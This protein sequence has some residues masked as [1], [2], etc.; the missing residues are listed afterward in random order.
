M[1]GDISSPSIAF[2][3]IQ[4]GDKMSIEIIDKIKAKNNGSF[5]IADASDVEYTNSAMTGV[6]NVSEAI[7]T[8]YGILN[9]APTLSYVDEDG[10][11]DGEKKYWEIGQQMSLVFQFTSSASGKCT[12]SITRNGLSY[13]TISTNKGRI[14]VDLGVA[15]TQNNYTYVVSGIDSIGRD[16]NQVLT[17][18]QVLGGVELASTFDTV[19]KNTVFT[20]NTDNNVT[21]PVSITYAEPG[22]PRNILYAIKN[23][24]T[25][26]IITSGEYTCGDR[27]WS[28]NIELQNIAF[29]APGTYNLTIQGK[30]S[31]GNTDLL[32]NALSYDFAAIAINSI[33]TTVVDFNADNLT[34]DTALSIA[35][36]TVTNV[37]ALVNTAK[38]MAVKCYLYRDQ[39]TAPIKE[40]RITGISSGENKIWNI[41]RLSNPGEYKYKLVGEPMS[42]TASTIT[43]QKSEG[44]FS[45]TQADTIGSSYETSNLI[46]YFDAN[47]MD[48]NSNNP[49][50]WP[51]SNDSSYYF[52]LHGLNYDRNGWLID[53]SDQSKM[54]KFSGDSYGEL[55]HITSSGTDEAYSPISL[56]N[57]ASL[58]NTF[59]IVFRTRCIGVMDTCVIS[60]R[61]EAITNY[62]G[63]SI[64]YDSAK[65][66][67]NEQSAT[68][69]INES[70][71]KFTHVAFVID[72]NI[73]QLK[74]NSATGTI[75]N[76]N[77]EDLNTVATMNIYVNG[78]RTKVIAVKDNEQFANTI[79]Y[80]SMQL[81]LNGYY[82]KTLREITGFGSCEIK[83]IRIYNAALTAS[84]VVGNYI[85]SVID[86]SKRQA[87]INKNDTNK[88]DIPVIRFVRNKTIDEDNNVAYSKYSADKSFSILNSIK[89]KKA[90][91]PNIPTSKN[92]WT[93]CTMWYTYLDK[94]QEI[95][96]TVKYE[97]VDVYLQG[98]SSLQFP[99]KNYK[100]KC[101]KTVDG[102]RGGKYKFIPPNK[103]GDP[104]WQIPDSVYTLKCD[105][106]EESHK[107]NTPTAAMYETVLDKVIEACQ[108][109]NYG[110][111][112]S[113]CKRADSNYAYSDAYATVEIDDNSIQVKKY[114]D[115]I[116]GFPVLLYYNENDTV[117]ST[118][119]IPVDYNALSN[120][121]DGYYV[122]DK[123]VMVGTMMFNLD[124]SSTALG[125]EPKWGE[126]I[127]VK[128]PITGEQ[129]KYT[130]GTDVVLTTVPCISVEG[131]S[132]SSIPSAASFYTREEANEFTYNEYVKEKYNTLIKSGVI[133][134]DTTYED[135]YADV[136]AANIYTD[137][138]THDEYM[139]NG[140]GIFKNDYDYITATFEIRWAWTE[141]LVPKGKSL[142]EQT[143]NEC[144]YGHLI[145]T[146][147]WIKESYNN[148]TKFKDEFSQ[149][150][151]FAYCCTYYLQMMTLIQVD[152]AGKNAMFDKWFG[153]DNGPD[154][155][156][157]R[158]RP[159][160]MDTQVCLDNSGEDRI[161]VSAEINVA[162]SPTG[163]SGT[164]SAQAAAS[165]METDHSHTRYTD[166]NTPNSKFWNAFG[167]FFKTEIVAV[168]SELRKEI[169][170]T[171]WLC[172]KANSLTSDIIGETFFNKDAAAKYMTQTSY[173]N[174]NGVITINDGM[175][176][177]LNGNRDSRYRQVI[178][179]RLIFMDTFFQYSDGDSLN[180][181]IVLRSYAVSAGTSKVQIGISV[182]S[183]CYVQIDIGTGNDAIIV[184]YIDTNEKYAYNDETYEGVLFTLPI[185]AN[186]KDI[187]I[188][189]AGNIKSINHM[190]NLVIS[191][192]DCANAKKLT[193]II[194][195]S[196]NSLTSLSTGSNTYLRTL[197]LSGST[198]V[199]GTIDLTY[200]ENIRTIDIS[201]T[202][203]TTIA[204]PDGGALKTF[205]AKNCGITAAMFKN[206]QFL[207][208]I[209]ITN[210]TGI[211][212]YEID[213]CPLITEVDTSGYINLN[214]V[215]ISNCNGIT[216]LNLS[217]TNISEMSIANCDRIKSIN[218][219][220]CNGSVMEQLNLST[221]YG[222]ETLNISSSQ[223]ANG[224]VLFLPK[225][226]SAIYASKPQS[227]LNDLV[228][229]GIDILWHELK[230]FYA[231]SSNL[232]N[233]MY[234]IS[235]TYTP[236]DCDFS[237]LTN[238]I[239]VKILRSAM[240]KKI[241]NFQCS[242]ISL[243][244]L[245]F[246]LKACE[247]ISGNIKSKFT[248][249]EEMFCDC[250]N[251]VNINNLTLDLSTITRA[252]GCMRNCYSI[253]YEI[254]KRTLNSM[255]NVNNLSE[256][257]YMQ[258]MNYN[259]LTLDS[260]MFENNTKVENLSRAFMRLNITSVPSG[261]FTPFKDTLKS[262]KGVF[263]G[264]S[265]LET[266]ANDIIKNCT[267]LITCMELFRGCTNLQN[268]FGSP[269]H[270]DI[271]PSNSNI[272]DVRLA[273]YQCK[274]LLASTDYTTGDQ[275]HGLK[276][277]FDNLPNIIQTDAMFDGCQ[278]ITELP[279]GLFESNTKLVSIDATFNRCTTIT[280]IP[281]KLFNTTNT[282]EL[283]HPELVRARGLFN[284]CT[285]MAGA[286]SSNF[287][288]GAYNLQDI[289]NAGPF[290]IGQINGPLTDNSY[291]NLTIYVGG[292]FANTA[293][294]GYKSN[295]L[296]KLTNLTSVSMLFYKGTNNS[297][298]MKPSISGNNNNALQFIY[299]DNDT[300]VVGAICNNI[301][302]G[303]TKLADVSYCFAGNTA[304]TKICNT[305]GS[306]TESPALFSSCKDT[307][308]TAE[309]LFAHCRNLSIDIPTALFKNC[310]NLVNLKSCY[311]GCASLTGTIT[312]DIFEGCP[313]IVNASYMFFKCSS[314]GIDQQ[315]TDIAIPSDLFDSCRSRL[316][317][318]SY[319]FAGC[320][321]M[322][323]QLQTGE[324]QII[325]EDGT[326]VVQSII[327]YGLLSDC[328]SLIS[329]CSMFRGCERLK[330]AIPE[331][332]F[333]TT[334][335]TK[336]YNNLTD[337]SYMFD[338]CRYLAL[339]STTNNI[340][341][342]NKLTIYGSPL[343]DSENGYLIPRNWLNKCPNITNIRYLFN[344]VSHYPNGTVT[345]P[346]FTVNNL[347]LD[348]STFSQQSKIQNANNAFA[349]CKSLSGCITSTF[350]Q[351]SLNTLTTAS[352]I[353]AFSGITSV[354]AERY[355][356]VFE[357]NTSQNAKNTVLTN[358]KEAFYAACGNNM[359]GY[360]PSIKTKFSA[361]TSSDGM[362]YDQTGL[363]NYSDFSIQQTMS[364]S[365]SDA[366]DSYKPNDIGVP[367]ATLS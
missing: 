97:D 211:S 40:I 279:E 128:N 38:S 2:V 77:I 290:Y 228:S 274:S 268:L 67:S 52:K 218:L 229:Q 315:A 332:I 343:S 174:K 11:R 278:F 309:G 117:D 162:L 262:A 302:D 98:T 69:P 232:T 54:L 8:I 143:F 123:D 342:R 178:D 267:E 195:P 183:P 270:Y 248:S 297:S 318:V 118:T 324:A 360:A 277:M 186:D 155:G 283:T 23:K 18:R 166:Y 28:S 60:C 305:D 137:I 191:Q 190:E 132:N 46:A 26:T 74:S 114:R 359:E 256:F 226:K 108:K 303:L 286:V 339:S 298:T 247:S 216:S 58:G 101:F 199:A 366:E 241:T 14:V 88:A 181:S 272:E 29:A 41:G 84:Q 89:T 273:F 349:H 242:N 295:F 237:Q 327:R 210:C 139:E 362:V 365:Y 198:R 276:C 10:Y 136:Q 364:S 264:C 86:I 203:I 239:E 100:I 246:G 215:L 225:Y 329:T 292:M 80:P 82:S 119:G 19:I 333:Y 125:F 354:G 109:N 331:D 310:T 325:N 245:F 320:T 148:K 212:S 220:G 85:N 142:D 350:M 192:F 154:L 165:N 322:R 317:N 24:D 213:N 48:N 65:I 209:D 147:N 202:N 163:I 175:L 158:P 358:I 31:L 168:Y 180:K 55:R 94:E 79:A 308:R 194:I 224:I 236:G 50:L 121:D 335:I 253:T 7:D 337:I 64:Y 188:H 6:N 161:N 78:V 250:S 152:N 204:L 201:N 116:N 103:I 227:E 265:N 3:T 323:G 111:A 348:D 299:V 135:F 151:D 197:N 34:T 83:M 208:T 252:D 314:I 33:A 122:N 167:T 344:Q 233:I 37:A 291:N 9:A 126:D 156:G 159:Y 207:E 316:T 36:I 113:P 205:I 164:Y 51:A 185:M 313:N 222:L 107:N 326:S 275:I 66:S 288:D 144:T 254:I 42:G 179:Q 282:S 173:E 214:K 357:K 73:R 45:I 90:A 353:F 43:I 287:F 284:N 169:Y 193:S 96:K 260:S 346:E 129:V 187:T 258:N 328:T 255:P 115:A 145:N 296:S 257:L 217:N 244:R 13:K 157:M 319:M 285:S 44:T 17:F 133:P 105:Y 334:T 91:D 231:E 4:E 259:T 35:F 170:T 124:K 340:D 304:L 21:I 338:N 289:G 271:F 223:P 12:I 15:T 184:A 32:S 330:G 81:I 263:L 56:M 307:L 341:A 345:D 1:L 269:N 171:N 150:F 294:T 22:F 27:D 234:G 311:A 104:E 93:N 182:Y 141:E 249:A 280:S 235:S 206:L 149:Y 219:S 63:Y 312:K 20:A 238:L 153:P 160:D 39:S 356:A 120:T 25:D 59:E 230:Y 30:V 53:T 99:I 172:D 281:S 87:L 367:A 301:F 76:S 62:G 47:D 196:S 355:Y 352:R 221:V 131:S 49:S 266:V 140:K 240:I 177:K 61:D 95:W 127:Y 16:A 134:E 200:C 146:I 92:S 5:K 71:D 347:S 75:T 102:A 300:P 306:N 336:L 189:A 130:D 72:K 363:E 293:I 138:N 57:S 321:G 261:L 106:M 112:Y 110:G 70:N 361:I 176:P 351:N 251:L 243:Y 68:T